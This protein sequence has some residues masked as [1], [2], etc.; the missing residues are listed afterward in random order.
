MPQSLRQSARFLEKHGEL[1]RISTVLSPQGVIPEIAR[2]AYAQKAPALL[3]ENVQGSPFAAVC[4]LFGT[5]DRSRLL[6]GSYYQDALLAVQAKAAPLQLL[7]SPSQWWRLPRIGLDALPRPAWG[8]AP[9][10]KHRTTLSQLP[11]IQSWPRDGGPFITLP[12]VLTLA[13]GNQSPL[14]ANVGMY[15]VQLAGNQ[16]IAD[17]ECGLHYQ[18][19]RGIGVHH[20]EALARGEALKVSI[21]VGGPAA[22]TLAAVMPLPEGMSELP[23]AGVLAGGAFRYTRWNGWLVSADADFCILGTLQPHTKPEG[24]FG[25]HLGYYSE[26]HPFPCLRVEHV[27][28]RPEPLWPFTVVGRPPQEDTTFGALVHDISAAMVPR[29]LPGIRAMH[30]VDAAGVH[31]LLLALGSE[32]YRPYAPR[33]PMELLTQAN[34]LLGFGQASLAKYLFIAA[35]D[36]APG[37]SLYNVPAFITHMLERIDLSRDLHFQ[38]STTMDTLDYSGT[39][40]DHGSKLVIAAAGA[41]RRT[42][43]TD[44]GSDVASLQLPAG[45]THTRSPLPGVLVI[46]GPVWTDAET[47]AN[48]RSLLARS[49]QHWHAREQWPWVTLCDNAEFTG[50]NVDNWLWVT[51]TRSNPSHD[52]AGVQEQVI[53][54]HWACSAPLI[55]DARRKS[56]HSPELVPDAATV[57]IVD[58]LCRPGGPLHGIIQ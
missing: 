38:T 26:T 24:P 52:I 7:R 31:P 8:G 46:Q 47:A 39:S 9:V 28:H 12:Q 3:F 22:H 10:L 45:F 33:E 41:P 30:A 20:Q 21:F 27:F 5:L 32:R 49:L 16:Y 48:Q 18:I 25:D 13:P 53:H 50:A 51:F 57:A 37:L 29:S 1:R 6:F 42:L 43:G 40:L 34:A 4:N 2:R 17:Q 15:R 44:P 55:V 14:S 35:H 36:D 19:H 23:F 11:Q 56:H 58:S 54:K